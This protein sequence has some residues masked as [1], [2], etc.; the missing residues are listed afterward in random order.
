MR[1]RSIFDLRL[2][3]LTKSQKATIGFVMSVCPSALSRGTTPLP[4]NGFPP[5]L[6]YEYF[7]KISQEN[8]SFIKI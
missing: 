4:L 8:S 3:A 5:S 6:I 2:D 1:L 7:S